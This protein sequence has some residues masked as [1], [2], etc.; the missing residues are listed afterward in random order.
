MKLRL[1]LAAATCLALP[2]A[3]HAQPVTGPY[4]S[5]EGGTSILNPINENESL[6]SSNTGLDTSGKVLYKNSY[7]GAG[8]VGYGFGDGF[9]V[10]ISG[11]YLRN[12]ASKVDSS[13]YGQFSNLGG[14][15]TYGPM[16]NVLYDANVG[17]PIFPYV[18]AGAGYQWAKLD[19]YNKVGGVVNASGTKG[20]FAFDVIAGLSYPISALPGLSLTLEYRFMMLTSSLNY[21]E[22]ITGGFP[23]GS[24]TGGTVKLGQE[25]SHTF[26]AGVR[27]QLFQ[28]PAPPPAPAPAPVAAPAPA[29]AKTYL[30]FFD[31]DK[32]VLTP[33]ATQI[34]AE[35]ASDSKTTS[36]TTIA[37]NGYTDTSGTPNYNLG[38][39]VRRAKAVEAQLVA[40]G[41]PESEIETHGYG[42]THLL[43]PT[44]PGVREPQ[45]RRVE[46]IFQ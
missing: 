30:V 20:S 7:A 3:A 23:P 46:I 39:S 32:A 28:P 31:W 42:E 13:S 24:P 44:G 6:I 36:V 38:L 12:Y 11:D 14:H 4:I 1:A 35:A 41:V 8:S 10:E 43:V 33:R 22:S 2:M 45:N 25:S 26:L 37:V 5:L 19:S 18:G 16:F 21:G 15:N 34:I 17:L 40:D 29:P 27:Y 9:R